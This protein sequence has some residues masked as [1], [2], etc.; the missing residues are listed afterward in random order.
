MQANSIRTTSYPGRSIL[1]TG[2]RLTWKNQVDLESRVWLEKRCCFA[3]PRF[4]KT[5]CRCTF[6]FWHMT[7]FK[8]ILRLG[9]GSS[10]YNI[11]MLQFLS[12]YQLIDSENKVAPSWAKFY[13][14]I[15]KGRE[16]GR[17]L[18]YKITLAAVKYLRSI[19]KQHIHKTGRAAINLDDVNLPSKLHIFAN[20][21]TNS[22]YFLSRSQYFN[23]CSKAVTRWLKHH[24]LPPQFASAFMQKITA[25]WKLHLDARKSG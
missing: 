7:I 20:T 22:T 24:G 1:C 5:V 10:F 15:Q 23:I 2:W 4:Q 12:F 21:N 3:T 19:A 8:R 18:T 17:R 11:K 13:T 25:E 9:F 14:T 16:D 6:R